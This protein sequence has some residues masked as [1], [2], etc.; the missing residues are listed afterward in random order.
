MAH[1]TDARAIWK[2]SAIA[3]ALKC[4]VSAVRG[5][6]H[7]GLLDATR[8]PGGHYLVAPAALRAYVEGA[9]ARERP[10]HQN[11]T[12]THQPDPCCATERHAR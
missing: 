9:A 7:D 3:A 1:W 10:T 6:C 8:T 5:W 11:L 12:K 4:S 2:V